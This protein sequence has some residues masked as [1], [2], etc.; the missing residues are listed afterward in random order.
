MS[1]RSTADQRVR[2]RVDESAG[3]DQNPG[4]HPGVNVKAQQRHVGNTAKARHGRRRQKEQHPLLPEVGHGLQ[5]DMV[6]GKQQFIDQ[7]QTHW[8]LSRVDHHTVNI[9]PK[10]PAQCTRFPPN[11]L[12]RRRV[13]SDR[14]QP[15]SPICMGTFTL[16][17]L[18]NKPSTNPGMTALGLAAN[19]LH[20]SDCAL[21]A[22]LRR[23]KDQL[24]ATKAVTA[25]AQKLASSYLP[26]HGG[27]TIGGPQHSTEP[28]RFTPQVWSC[29][30]LT[31]VNFPS[32]GVAWPS[33]L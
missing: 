28:S 20:R 31:E 25:A 23:K 16:H 24:D 19:A 4:H 14:S 15:N 7:R 26:N 18:K 13:R 27:N 33:A 11:P 29:P 30:A 5:A 10:S 2:E 12:P 8:R 9:I 32:G 17:E 21:D 22:S 6:G 1:G 3:E